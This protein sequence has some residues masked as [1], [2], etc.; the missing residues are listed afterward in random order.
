MTHGGARLHAHGEQVVAGQ[1]RRAN[2]GLF[3][4]LFGLFD[5]IVINI[6]AAMG[7][8]AIE[9]MK[10]E[11]EREGGA[12]QEAT[13]G[14]FAHFQHVFELHM[15]ADGDDDVVDLFARETEAFEDLLGHIRAEAFVIVKMNVAG[16]WIARGGDGFGD[17]VKKDGPWEGWVCV[18][19]EILEHEEEVIEHRSFRMKIGGLVARDGGGDF[20]QDLFEQAALAKE[21]EAT[22]GVR[23]AEELDEFV[24]DALGADGVNFGR[25]GFD[26]RKGFRLDIEI[27]LG[28]ETNGAKEA[29]MIFAEAF[30]G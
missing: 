12:H 7:A 13:E 15:A 22:R 6:E 1:E 26:G 27:Q 4:E 2:F 28:G 19:G 5:E 29:K 3:F 21:V 17:V 8:D 18:G 20:G 30:G 14:G 9:A 24:A 11:F 10:L 16:M 25:G 23:R